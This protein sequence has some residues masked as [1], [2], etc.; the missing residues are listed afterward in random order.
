[1]TAYFSLL[2]VPLLIY[3]AKYHTIKHDYEWLQAEYLNNKS[4]TQKLERLYTSAHAE[5]LK[6]R[7]TL[8]IEN[9]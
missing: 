6:L 4:Y 9:E 5:N 2:I 1:M 7:Q 8:K 3:M